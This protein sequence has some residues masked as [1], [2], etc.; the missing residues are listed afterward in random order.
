MWE[1]REQATGPTQRKYSGFTEKQLRE[2]RK[3]ARG[4]SRTLS[5]NLYPEL[6]FER[7]VKKH[8]S[9]IWSLWAAITV[10]F[11]LFSV[12]FKSQCV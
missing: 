9:L 4:H 5:H 10:K 2:N 6:F 3:T 8:S 11:A 1:A 12:H 7:F